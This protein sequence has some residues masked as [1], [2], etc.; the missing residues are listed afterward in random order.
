MPEKINPKLL[1]LLV[2]P[3]THGRLAF[4]RERDELISVSAKLAYP[5]K[6]GVPMMLEDEAR[7]L[8]DEETESYRHR[9]KP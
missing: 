6:G 2:C 4:D 5:I 7:Q 3:V 9:Y 1:E 8:S